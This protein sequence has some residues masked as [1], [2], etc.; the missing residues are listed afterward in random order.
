MAK[1]SA[2]GGLD[3]G[4]RYLL[5]DHCQRERHGLLHCRSNLQCHLH[6][7]SSLGRI[8]VIKNLHLLPQHNFGVPVLGDPERYFAL[9]SQKVGPAKQPIRWIRFEEFEPE[10]KRTASSEIRYIGESEGH[11]ISRE[12]DRRYSLIVRKLCIWGELKP[13]IKN[14]RGGLSG[15]PPPLPAS[16][17]VKSLAEE[18]LQSMGLAATFSEKKNRRPAPTADGFYACLQLRWGDRA[19]SYGFIM[20]Q[21]LT[22][23]AIRWRLNRIADLPRGSHLYI[24]SDRWG[25]GYFD[26]LKRDYKVWRCYD[27]PQLRYLVPNTEGDGQNRSRF[28]SFFLFAIELELMKRAA[29]KIF[30]EMGVGSKGLHSGRKPL[31]K[32]ALHYLFQRPAAYVKVQR[33]WMKLLNWQHRKLLNWQHRW[34]LVKRMLLLLLRRK[35]I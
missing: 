29:V 15:M 20:R 1:K 25:R 26:A 33:R 6:E 14:W 31:E 35:K 5:Y 19:R 27:F 34:K 30:T 23:R 10:L 4:Q 16:K 22:A 8:A 12:D 13:Q 28:D 7:A 17:E 24:M 18:I 32:T 2:E 3:S 11:F 21:F 9:P